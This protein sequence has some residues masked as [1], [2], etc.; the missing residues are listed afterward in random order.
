MNGESITGSLVSWSYIDEYNLWKSDIDESPLL[1]RAWVAQERLLAPR[2]L[3]F[4][5]TEMIWECNGLRACESFPTGFP[6]SCTSTIVSLKAEFA[7]L[8]TEL[9]YL[10]WWT[11][12]Q[13]SYSS[14]A[15]TKRGD[16]II[17]VAGIARSFK[18]L[19]G[20]DYHAGIWN[21]YFEIQLLW[22][23][24]RMEREE[25]VVVRTES[26]LPR[27]RD[28]HLVPSH[29]PDLSPIP[30]WSCGSYLVE[31]FIDVSQNCHICYCLHIPMRILWRFG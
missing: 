29:R 7:N 1:A 9:D 4:G 23:C 15:L 18:R 24:S 14:M 3:H 5:K 13:H 30:T 22:Q 16:R 2:T 26:R 17:A 21:R 12:L 8:T 11:T 20:W 27:L 10:K 31:F 19:S 6:D 28:H 25:E